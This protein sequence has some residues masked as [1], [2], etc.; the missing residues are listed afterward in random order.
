MASREI[1]AGAAYVEFTGK[2]APL[3]KALNRVKRRLNKWGDSVGQLG[4]RVAAAGAAIVAPMVL[5]TRVFANAGDKFDKMSKRTGVSVEAL[6][7]LE[8]AAQQSGAS[9]E[10]LEKSMA[11]MS[12]TILDAERGLSTAT[13]ALAEVGLSV[14]DLKGL[15]P[16]KQFEKLA[17]AI[18]KVDDASR[19]TAIARMIFGRGG[20][21]LLPLINEGADGIAMLRAEAAELGLTMSTETAVAAAR[22][23]DAMNRAKQVVLRVVIAVGEALEPA[24][25][26]ASNAIAKS[27]KAV[28][29]W[30]NKNRD[31]I[32]TALAVG[33]GLISLGAVIVSV[34]LALKLAAFAAGGFATVITL[35]G[36]VMGVILSP[37]GLVTA[38]VIGLLMTFTDATNGI[39][40]AVRWLQDKFAGML[41]A[42]RESLG[43][44]GQAL[45]A[46]EVG[47]A[48]DVLWATLRLAWTK[49][50][51][52]L[53]EKWAEWRT[54][55]TATAIDAMGRLQSIVAKGAAAIQSVWA[56]LKAGTKSTWESIVNGVTKEFNNIK[57]LTDSSLNAME[58]VAKK[59]ELDALAD[60]QSRTNQKK[61]EE[62]RSAK[63]RE[64][65]T[66]LKGELEKINAETKALQAANQVAG[67]LDKSKAQ[68]ALE[69]AVKEWQ[70]AIVAARK[71]G[72]GVGEARGGDKFKP[73]DVA[74]AATATVDK[75]EKS[76]S[77]GT[78][79]A[80]AVQGLAAGG[81]KIERLAKAMERTEAN[82]KRMVRAI[83]RGGIP[84]T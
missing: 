72:G 35:I 51:A 56:S 61:I 28:K 60:G 77:R 40:D 57:V 44:M 67:A 42:L 15:A 38:A 4:R 29:E 83:E 41:D 27:A 73:G 54:F 8:F 48:A 1:R 23:S 20:A 11:R 71:A 32:R 58:K 3:I 74:E 26:A 24:M 82:T 68:G 53:N 36:S 25:T 81:A 39:G 21:E 78:F 70:D 69:K 10:A 45:A 50:V 52:A 76:S 13:D 33:V 75:I 19:K 37:I 59:K 62:Q 47:K 6:S 17:G 43:A 30:V 7:E 66:G 46:G 5:A 49:G 18:A 65:D 84:F 9:V 34:G 31:A 80:R 16:D 63:Q 55:L 12:G 64:I 22:L 2:D 79:N 14:D